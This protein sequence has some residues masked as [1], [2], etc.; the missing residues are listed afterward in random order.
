MRLE[1]G[2]WVLTVTLT[3]DSYRKNEAA[4]SI[5][6]DFET[7]TLSK[8]EAVKS[9]REVFRDTKDERFSLKGAVE[10]ITR[11]KIGV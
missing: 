5:R 7:G 6:K 2:K 3:D 11:Q 9:L 1:I 4:E 10:Y 8:I